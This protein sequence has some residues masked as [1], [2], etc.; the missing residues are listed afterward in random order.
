MNGVEKYANSEVAKTNKRI[1]EVAFNGRIA[2]RLMD[3]LGANDMCDM[4]QSGANWRLLMEGGGRSSTCR[5][6]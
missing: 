1:V 4:E 3:D 2:T 6:R 5:I